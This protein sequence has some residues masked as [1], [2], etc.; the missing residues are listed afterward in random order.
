MTELDNLKKYV[1]DLEAKILEMDKQ[2][3]KSQEN[4]IETQYALEQYILHPAQVRK[5]FIEMVKED[6]GI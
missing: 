5:D 6:E 2:I 3:R 1:L 4:I